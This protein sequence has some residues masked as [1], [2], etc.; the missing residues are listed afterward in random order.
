MRLD[1]SER[2]NGAAARAPRGARALRAILAGAALVAAA[3]PV[4]AQEAFGFGDPSGDS[5]ASVAAA[6]AKIGAS[7]GGEIRFSSTVFPADVSSLEN[8]DQLVPET[9][10]LAL[11]DFQAKGNSAEAGF[12]LKVSKE[13]LTDDPTK[14][15]DEAY[16]RFFKGPLT[17]EGGLLKLAWG[18]ADSLGP[19]DV[20]NPTDYSDLTVTDTLERK[21]AQPMI[22]ATLALGDF[23]ALQLVYLPSFQ[24]NTIPWDGRW[25]PGAVAEQLATLEG[26]EMN[27]DN[28]DLPTTNSLGWSQAGAR[29]TTSVGGVDL[30]AQYYWGY[31]RN[32]AISIEDLA[33]A[34]YAY[35][36]MGGAAATA[37]LMIDIL[38]NRYHQIGVDA[39]TVLAG[40]N[41]RSEL[42]ANITGD[43]S[44]DDP[45]VYNP[46]V[47]WSLGFDR[48]LIWGVN[49]NLQ[50]TGMVRLM[51]D[52]VG[53]EG[54]D[55][56]GG[57]DMSAT[58]ITAVLSKKFLKDTVETKLVGLYEVEAEDYLL[59]PQLLYYIDDATLS[60]S[61]GI[62]GGSADGAL[63]YYADNSYV[64]VSFSYKF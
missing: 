28:L 14:L 52:Q 15:I 23:S 1:T 43:F 63:G 10:A 18:K 3:M 9:G 57:T 53:A 46:S 64:K 8:L 38:Y 31:L 32:P 36:Y 7:V 40:F 47:A 12:K 19:L 2:G 21:I 48:D 6:P 45:D 62:F 24:A 13:I 59:T 34:Y 4:A 51:D 25:E 29:I 17:L 55:I 26:W 58:T 16:V 11:L 37:N 39:A 41:L 44:G 49:L 56:E 30:G 50:G 5:G 60:L 20:L 27:I 22:H 61:G 35:T 54:T 42:A 33:T